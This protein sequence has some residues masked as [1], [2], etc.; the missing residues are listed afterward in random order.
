MKS[1]DF[2]QSESKSCRLEFISAVL[3]SIPSFNA[4][5][6]FI[7]QKSTAEINSLFSTSTSHLEPPSPLKSINSLSLKLLTT[8][9]DLNLFNPSA[10][11]TLNDFVSNSN[12]LN[13]VIFS[14][15]S[16]LFSSAPISRIVNLRL[17]FNLISASDM[18]YKYGGK[19]IVAIS[20]A[21]LL[22]EGS[23]GF[24]ADSPRNTSIPSS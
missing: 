8:K 9:P 2:L 20:S 14:K 16:I 22:F 4:S 1:P 23:T 11:L 5:S 12:A 18:L 10:S 19:I 15:F 7:D 6:G 24:S 3:T 13:D 21:S 17:S